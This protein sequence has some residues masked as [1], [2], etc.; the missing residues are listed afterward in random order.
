MTDRWWRD[1][2]YNP[3][4]R[5]IQYEDIFSFTLA[6]QYA[7]SL[8]NLEPIEHETTSEEMVDMKRI[9]VDGPKTTDIYENVP[10]IHSTTISC[11]ENTDYIG[12]GSLLRIQFD[13]Q[14]SIRA[15]VTR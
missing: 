4:G 5:L 13:S 14:F 12:K 1:R 11:I 8:T 3:V 7:S 9:T 15:R 10:F 6:R 2:N